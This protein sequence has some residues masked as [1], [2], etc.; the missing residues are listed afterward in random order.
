MKKQEC[1]N[2]MNVLMDN[3]RTWLLEASTIINNTLQLANPIALQLKQEWI[4]EVSFYLCIYIDGKCC[5]KTVL[6]RILDI[7][8]EG[9]ASSIAMKII[10]DFNDRLRESCICKAT[11][12]FHTFDFYWKVQNVVKTK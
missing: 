12:A 3:Q 10:A 9:C 5:G 6:F 11:E 8:E 2:R 4:Y 1:K 7:P